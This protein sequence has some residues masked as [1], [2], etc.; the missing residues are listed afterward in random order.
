MPN[1]SQL[2]DNRELLD[3]SQNLSPVRPYT[4]AG[5]FPDR[6]TQYIEQEYTRLCRNGNL[7]VAASVHAFDTEARIGSRIPFET[8][9]TEQLLIKE[10]INLTES[11]RRLTRG[12]SMN[13]D[14]LREYVFDDIARMAERVITRVEI[15]KMDVVSK[16]KFT[17]TENG[18][19]IPIDYDIPA[20]NFVNDLWDEDAD[21]LGDVRTWRA[22]AIANGSTPTVALTSEKVVT[23]IMNNANVQ[24]AIFGTSGTG[25]LPSMEQLNALFMS[26]FGISIRTDEERYGEIV[27][28]GGKVKVQQKRFFPEGKFV[29]LS[30]GANGTLGTGLWGVTPEEEEQGGAFDTK[31]QQQFVT[32]TTWDTP[33]PVTTWTKASGLFMPVMPNPYGHVIADVTTATESSEGSEG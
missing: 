30:T 20:E 25:V 27:T 4:G 22:L 2:I 33:D 8:V 11:V 6:K 7:P 5:L 14:S 10:K 12:L 3:F 24:K 15:A 23:T 31:R 32:V 21:I 18:L 16:G 28:D 9:T 26:Q 17:I 1:I 29:L 19:D 13:V